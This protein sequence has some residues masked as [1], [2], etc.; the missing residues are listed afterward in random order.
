MTNRLSDTPDRD[1]IRTLSKLLLTAFMLVAAALTFWGVL[2]AAAI[3]GR[4]DNPRLVEA[5]LRIQRCSI[6]DRND[7]VLAENIGTPQRQE[8]S[9][10]FPFVGPAIG[11]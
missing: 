2:R 1:K 8:R 3:L 9:Y 6:L 11:Y 4:D 5:E 7:K 10:P